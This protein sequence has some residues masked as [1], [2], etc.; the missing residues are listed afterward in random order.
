M[1]RRLSRLWMVINRP[2]YDEDFDSASLHRSQISRICERCRLVPANHQSSEQLANTTP[3]S[4]IDL[5]VERRTNEQHQKT[6]FE[7]FHSKQ[8][9]MSISDASR[10]L[11]SITRYYR[12]I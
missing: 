10:R 5:D 8:M 2:P 12:V 7:L 1:R 9:A 4:R 3:N 6:C 11:I